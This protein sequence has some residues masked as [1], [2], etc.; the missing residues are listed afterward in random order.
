[1]EGLEAAG[2]ERGILKDIQKGMRDGKKEEPVARAVKELQGLSARSVTSAECSL[3]NKLLYF[4]GKI[5]VLDTSNLS[6]W[7]VA[8]SHD[9]RLAGHSGRWKALELVSRN[10]W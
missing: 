4:Q 7:I 10:Y 9:S 6:C 5:Y 8:L 3:S 2:E 1:L